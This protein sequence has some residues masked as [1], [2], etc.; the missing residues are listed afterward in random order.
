VL[1]TSQSYNCNCCCNINWRTV[2]VWKNVISFVAWVTKF[3]VFCWC[4]WLAIQKHMHKIKNNNNNNNNLLNVTHPICLSLVSFINCCLLEESRW[5]FCLWSSPIVSR[6]RLIFGIPSI[7]TRK[8]WNERAIT[9][10]NS[11]RKPKIFFKLL[12]VSK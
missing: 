8:S 1:T 12:K 7:L 2:K 10:R 4:W 3:G 11:S 9:S 5:V 6:I